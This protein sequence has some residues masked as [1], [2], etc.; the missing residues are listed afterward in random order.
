VNAKQRIIVFVGLLTIA[1][2]CIF[3]PWKYRYP[4]VSTPAEKAAGHHFIMTPPP[5]KTPEELFGVPAKAMREGKG[6]VII[7]SV[8]MALE[9]LCILTLATGVSL[10]IK[11]RRRR[12]DLSMGIFLLCLGGCIS[13]G[14]IWAYFWL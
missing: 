5:L 7:H 12:V 3:P 2:T 6:E 14:T 11:D 8:Q 10:L 4:A 13:V 9:S 1:L